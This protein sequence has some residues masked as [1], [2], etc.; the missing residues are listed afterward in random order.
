[1]AAFWGTSDHNR[2]A[3]YY[4][5]TAKGRRQLRRQESRWAELVCA[6]NRIVQREH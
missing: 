6:I 4:R 3:R 2:R 5:L 1:V